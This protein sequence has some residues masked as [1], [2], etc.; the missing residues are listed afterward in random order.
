[1]V[2][3]LVAVLKGQTS[4]RASMALGTL[5]VAALGGFYLAWRHSQKALPPLAVVGLHALLAVGGFLTLLSVVAG[6]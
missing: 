3:V 2:L 4:G 6:F 5:V 1:L